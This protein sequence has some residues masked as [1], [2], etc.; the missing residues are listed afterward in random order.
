[1]Q[2]QIGENLAPFNPTSTEVINIALSLLQLTPSDC[3]FDLG[4]G[5]GRLLIAA[6]KLVPE[7]KV[8][9]VEYDRD[10]FE[11]GERC[12]CEV[13]PTYSCNS[14]S[15]SS[16]IL[17]SSSK[18]KHDCNEVGILLIHADVQ[19]VDFSDGT[20]FFIY[21]VP[22]GIATLRPVLINLLERGARIVTYG[23]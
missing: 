14:S 19:T 12:I 11:R 17:L 10:L 5:D 16:S 21:L 8:I 4:C 22:K 15:S 6:K 3:F 2:M 18:V 13:F 23:K 9:G 1:M 7:L 20:A